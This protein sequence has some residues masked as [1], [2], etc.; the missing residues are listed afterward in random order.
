[1]EKFESLF[2]DLDVHIQVRRQYDLFW[3]A[4][5]LSFNSVGCDILGS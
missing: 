5:V 3:N 1:M 2:E 4:M